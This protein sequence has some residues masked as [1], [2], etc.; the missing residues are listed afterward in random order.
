MCRRIRRHPNMGGRFLR[1]PVG[2]PWWPPIG[3]R[4]GGFRR[5]VGRRQ[6]PGIYAVSCRGLVRLRSWDGQDVDGQEPGAG[7]RAERGAA[8]ARSC[9]N[10]GILGRPGMGH[11]GP[12]AFVNLNEG[13]RRITGR[14]EVDKGHS[15]DDEGCGR[16]DERGCRGKGEY[17]RE[18][19]QEH[20][21][22]V[23]KCIRDLDDWMEPWGR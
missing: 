17:E 3:G 8:G 20:G 2:V 21:E 23:M 6:C 9:S 19:R 18:L 5:P 13:G 10:R 12:G 11:C 1:T 16:E 22:N 4:A 14:A 15:R 7:G